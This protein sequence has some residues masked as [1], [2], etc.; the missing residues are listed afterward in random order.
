MDEGVQRIFDEVGCIA[1]HTRRFTT[2]D[3]EVGALAGQVI[4][5][6]T[7]LLLHD[8]GPGLSDGRRDGTASAQEWKTPALWG[9]GLTRAVNPHAGFLHDGRAR[10]IEEAVLWH[11]GEARSSRDAWMAL[12]AEQRELLPIFLKSL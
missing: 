12:P 10:S 11:G 8:M 5:P 3:H 7:D 6:Y 2:G 9:L 4:Y 1:C